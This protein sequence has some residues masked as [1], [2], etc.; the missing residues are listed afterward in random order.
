MTRKTYPK[1][2]SS[3]SS[4][5]R[6]YKGSQRAQTTPKQGGQLPRPP[7][8]LQALRNLLERAESHVQPNLNLINDLR[9]LIAE[10]EAKL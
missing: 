2:K 6:P 1:H 5:Q 4:H 8:R 9:K 3:E 10:A 7:A